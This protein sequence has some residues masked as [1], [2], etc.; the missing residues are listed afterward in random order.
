[1]LGV[2]A[3]ADGRGEVADDGFGDAVDAEGNRWAAEAVLNPANHGAEEQAGR[4]IAAA[5]A[6]INGEQQ[7]KIEDGEFGY[8]DG[9]D[10][11]QHEGDESGDDNRA[12]IKLVDFDVSF[13][14]AEFVGVVHGCTGAAG[15]ALLAAGAEVLAAGVAV[16]S[17]GNS[18][19]CWD[20]R[21]KTSSRRSSFAA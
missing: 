10:G 20:K 1:M 12:G 19:G 13:A 7:G 3:G 16:A 17:L 9:N 18:S 14:A 21:I 2:Q 4:G 11:L 6:E 8:V 15:V 5:Q